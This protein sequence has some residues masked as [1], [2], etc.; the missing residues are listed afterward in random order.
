VDAEGRPRFTIADGAR[1]PD[2]GRSGPAP[3][4][5]RHDGGGWRRS[6]DAHTESGRPS[7]GTGGTAR[8]ATSS[9]RHRRRTAAGPSPSALRVSLDDAPR[10]EF[11]DE[12][13]RV[14]C[15]LPPA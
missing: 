15:S 11:L 6:V 10:I 14:T 12:E 13:G 4:R 3:A 7:T 9:L 8:S 1:Q 2:V 5:S